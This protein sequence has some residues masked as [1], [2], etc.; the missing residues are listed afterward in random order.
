MKNVR[1][2]NSFSRFKTRQ[3]S[4]SNDQN[5]QIL[6]LQSQQYV[7]KLPP[8]AQQVSFHLLPESYQGSKTKY[9]VQQ[10]IQKPSN[11]V[12][13][14]T[15]NYLSSKYQANKLINKNSFVKNHSK[16]IH[17]MSYYHYDSIQNENDE[18][19]MHYNNLSNVSFKEYMDAETRANKISSDK[20][21][22]IIEGKKLL[23][24]G[25]TEEA[26]KLF[27]EILQNSNNPEARYL[28]GLCHLSKSEF[29]E[30]IADLSLLIQQQP[31]YKR[32]AYILLAIAYKKSNCPNDALN[33]LTLSIKQFNKYF[34][35]YIYRGKLL[36]KM[37]QFDRALKDF[38]CAVE[39]QPKKAISYI[40]QADCYRYM[41]Q[42][43]LSVQ[44]CTQAIECQDS[45]FRQALIKRTLL[46]IDLKEYDLALQD[47]QA[48]LEEDYCDSEALYIKGF[49]CTKKN[50]I[51]EAF[52]A[53]EQSI[54]HNNSKKAVSKSLYEIAKIKIEQR[55]FYEAFYQ[56]SRADYLDVD[57][58]ILEK[59]KIFTDGVTFLMKRKFDEGVE[60]LTTLITKHQVTDFLKPLIFQYRAYGYFC[61]SQYQK[62]L[63]DLNQLTSLEKP[64]IY[65]KLIAEGILAAVAN[66]FEQS[67]GFFLKAQK[68]MPNKMEPYFYKA[69]TLVKFYSYL[70]PK[71]DIEKKN[72]FLNDAIKYMDMAVKINE[73]SNLLF[74]RGIVLF[75]QGRLDDSLIDLDKAIEKSEDHVAKHFYVRGLIQAN[76]EAYEP[77]LNDLTI[78]L[79][80]DE[81][82]VD[83]YLNRAKVFLLLGDRKNAY[84][85]AQKYK[86]CKQNDPQTDI[87]LGNLFFQIGVYE[88]AIESYSKSI[89]S[90]KSL[91][92]LYFR[93]K[94]Y[95]LIKELNSSMLDLQK[96]VEQSNDIHAIVDLNVLQQLKNTS[97]AN[98]DQNIF[99]EALQCV[100][101][102][103]KKGAEG[104]IFKK[105]DIL[106]YKGLFQFY[107]KQYD[108]AQQSLRESYKIKE[109]QQKKELGSM[110]DSD[111]YIL[112]QLNQTQK[113][114]EFKS[115]PLE[116]FEF[117]DRTYNLYEYYFNRSAIHLLLGQT[118][119]ALHYLEQL[120]E[121]IQQ[122]EIQEHLSLFIQLLK[123]DQNPKSEINC[124]LSKL[125]E[126]LIFPQ[127]NRLCSIYPMI[128]LPLKKYKQNLQLRL[129]FCLPTIEIPEMNIKF[130][131]K[132]IETISPTVVENKPEAPWIKRTAEGVIFTDNVQIVEDLDLQS[133]T[134]QSKKQTEIEDPEFQQFEDQLNHAIE[135]Y[136][137]S[138]ID[139]Q[140]D[141]VEQQNQALDLQQLKQNLMLDSKIA[142]KLNSILQKKAQ[143]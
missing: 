143:N 128:K 24:L 7:K 123:D 10:V 35:A 107:L 50:Q 14:D 106:F 104:K 82:L 38:T 17:S 72:K 64:S 8:K 92:V 79:N 6:K 3:K 26:Q 101:Q 58:K 136:D 52:L 71:D 13:N 139:Q 93:A 48:V 88:D 22:E 9:M 77:A 56:L 54:K 119:S 60:T 61:Q 76:R 59:F 129:S 130:D 5:S 120:Q 15:H 49:I 141:I 87:I 81:K 103:L 116:E 142:D 137:Y 84:Y 33:T 114:V 91:Q 131:D 16:K 75:A 37:K 46:Y 100:N 111:Q 53:Y 117:S 121:N 4:R 20:S 97:T 112:D 70:I 23:S 51:Q 12:L 67:Q 74:Y 57:E 19:C 135:K 108:S 39:I 31:L 36:L 105:S 18:L 32:N 42:P 89:S 41:N 29:S 110:N 45:S 78:A 69:T 63:N 113:K 99:Q 40:G 62:A 68:L 133:T 66:Q 25:Q 98:N 11:K 21:Q 2:S 124:E 44:A 115:K 109:D 28:N 34:D 118:E 27:E 127:H 134:R 85:D 94:T 80:L 95:I 1:E 83:A 43:K 126:F 73:Q 138:E 125:T 86:E 122:L 47:I 55:D 96:I 30:A 132:L 102:I 65:N 140:D 90:E